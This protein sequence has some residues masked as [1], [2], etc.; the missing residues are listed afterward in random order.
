MEESQNPQVSQA[1]IEQA[2][3]SDSE[4]QS[5]LEKVASLITDL[6]RRLR[7]LEERYSN[8]RKKLQLTD[9][10]LI[11]SERSFGKELR[12]FSDELLE[13]KRNSNDFSEKTI[14][15]QN[16]LENTAKKNDV[17][18]LEKYLALWSPSTFVTRSELREYL[19]SPMRRIQPNS[20]E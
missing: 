8:L 5:D 2:Q 12:T 11:E 7:T 1:T 20:E 13:L 15:F 3:H 16:E 19:N 4:P 6:D 14:L 17:K 18:V 9:Q 10:N